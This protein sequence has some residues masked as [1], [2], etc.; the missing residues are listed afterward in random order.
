MS[1]ASISDTGSGRLSLSELVTFKD[2]IGVHV[3]ST[4]ARDLL[5]LLNNDIQAIEDILELPDYQPAPT[6]HIRDG[7]HFVPRTATENKLGAWAYKCDVQPLEEDLPGLLNGGSVVLK[8]NVALAGVPCLIG[9]EVFSNW[10]PETDATIVS[11]ILKAG[12]RIKGKAVCENLCMTPAS[13]SA[14]TGRVENPYALGFTTGGSSSGTGALVAKGEVEYGIGADQGGSIRIP[15]AH[16]GLVGMKATFGLIPY[17]GCVSG[18]F[19]LDNVGPMTKT[20]S[21]NAR[22]LQAIAGYDGIDD[23]AGPGCPSPESLPSYIEAATSRSIGGMK[24]GILKEA[25]EVPL[26]RESMSKKVIAAAYKFRDLGAIVEEVSIPFHKYSGK[27]IQVITRCGAGNAQSGRS[28]GRRGLY[29]N[30]LQDKM[31][32]QSAEAAAKTYFTVRNARLV[33]EYAWKNYPSAYGKAMNLVRKLRDAY[34]DALSKYDLL[35]LPVVNY[36]ARRHPDLEAL[37][38]QQAEKFCKCH[39]EGSDIRGLI[40]SSGPNVTYCTV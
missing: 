5:V 20:V 35:V 6:P 28:S 18:E 24:I 30:D 36:P 2:R 19:I 26:L 31:F 10:I 27:I 17:T 23:R 40:R 37:P 9:T 15:A 7:V 39:G 29:M 32:P 38:L 1:I 21:S 11:R 13:N 25:F 8:D 3:G 33:G 34:N 4:E 16:C 14:T 22:L 12:G